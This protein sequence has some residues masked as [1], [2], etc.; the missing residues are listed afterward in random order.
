MEKLRRQGSRELKRIEIRQTYR[1][2][3]SAKPINIK[4]FITVKKTILHTNQVNVSRVLYQGYQFTAVTTNGR[5]TYRKR[6]LI[7]NY[8]DLLNSIN[9]IRAIFLP[10]SKG[11]RRDDSN[12]LG[13]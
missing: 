5:R 12:L 9:F 4:C 10:D 6:V 11:S 1:T 2:I 8:I 3:T 7:N 13:V